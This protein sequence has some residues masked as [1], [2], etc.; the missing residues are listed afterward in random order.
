MTGRMGLVAGRYQLQATLGKGGM[1]VVFA[2][3]DRL[4]NERVALKRVIAP[5]NDLW[6]NSRPEAN[7]DLRIALAHEFRTLAALRHPHIITVLDYGFNTAGQPFFT[8]PLVNRGQDILTAADE[9]PLH[10]KVAFLLQM[11]QALAYLHRRGIIHRDLKPGNVLVDG[12]GQVRVLDFGL[13]AMSTSSLNEQGVGGTFSYLAPEIV[14][15]NAASK[16]SDIYAAGVLAYEV[17][18][19]EHPFANSTNLVEDI[20]A[21]KV[22]WQPLPAVVCAIIQKMMV[23]DPKRRYPRVEIVIEDLCN[24]LGIGLPEES[25]DIREGYLQTAEFCGREAELGRLVEA[26]ARLTESFAEPVLPAQGS[27]AWLIGGESGVGK[28]RLVEEVRVRALTEG[29]LALRGQAQETG[30]LPYQIWREAARRL[31]LMVDVPDE[32]APYLKAIVPDIESLLGRSIADLTWH[33]NHQSRLTQAIVRLFAC[34]PKPVVLLLEDLQWAQGHSLELL[35]ALI[36]QLDTLPVL[37]IGTFRTEDWAELPVEVNGMQVMKLPRLNQQEVARLSASM[38]GIAGEQPHVVE[39]LHR[40]TEGN[41]FFLVEVVRTLAEEAG[42]LE[43]VGKATLPPI[44]FAGGVQTVIARR[45]ARV[46]E[47]DQLLLQIAA[48][49]GRTIDPLLMQ[50][51]DVGVELERWLAA[52]T[53]VAVLEVHE[54]R[55]RFAHDKLR[56]YLLDMLTP[57][58]RAGLHQVVALALEKIYPVQAAGEYAGILAEHWRTAGH[59]PNEHH[60]AVKAGRYFNQIG[61]LEEAK[62]FFR[63]ADTLFGLLGKAATESIQRV[64][65]GSYVSESITAMKS[66]NLPAATKALQKAQVIADR[67]GDVHE[68]LVV[69]YYQCYTTLLEGNWQAARACLEANLAWAEAVKDS[70][71]IGRALDGLSTVLMRLHEPALAKRHLERALRVNQSLGMG[72]GVAYVEINLGYAQLQLGDYAAAT[73][74]MTTGLNTVRQLGYNSEVAWAL[75]GLGRLAQLQGNFAQALLNLREAVRM[76]LQMGDHV[77]LLTSLLRLGLLYVAMGKL[78]AAAELLG[79]V[80]YQPNRTDYDLTQAEDE[81]KTVLK[82]RLSESEFRTAFLQGH[83]RTL[84]AVVAEI[85]R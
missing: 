54:G 3:L 74:L 31:V 38:L 79:V 52:C 14:Q 35:T 71:S 27:R 40:E 65:L 17:L 36:A 80:Q 67:L 83:G 60:A 34:Q 13:A 68:Q 15:G 6:F 75:T 85:L 48:V 47:W 62:R 25:W 45:V 23:V 77:L 37:L 30:G 4:T 26:L 82:S 49:A 57:A 76:T 16:M 41:A 59:L 73:T 32:D 64:Q 58:E 66:S 33:E 46:T 11:L 53:D 69:D 2:A 19:G 9:L 12:Q 21:G 7:A 70:D 39:V 50:A 42:G 55:W 84:Q 43:L 24:A 20:E 28:S 18:T 81:L 1:G 22:N 5:T 8:M 63:E 78:P 56:E 29:A 51:T 72:Y 44:I 61:Y 10:G